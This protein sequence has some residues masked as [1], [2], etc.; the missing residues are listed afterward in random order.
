MLEKKVIYNG[1]AYPNVSGLQCDENSG[2]FK[3]G[4]K[5]EWMGGTTAYKLIE[6]SLSL[7]VHVDTV[8]P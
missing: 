3:M 8:I 6:H 4:Y 2:M 7:G 1:K 5:F